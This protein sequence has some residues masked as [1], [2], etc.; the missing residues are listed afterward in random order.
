MGLGTMQEL[1]INLQ[2]KIRQYPHASENPLT[3]S[4][5]SS[6]HFKTIF[7]SFCATPKNRKTK[8]NIRRTQ[9]YSPPLTAC[10]PRTR[11]K[12]RAYKFLLFPRGSVSSID[13]DVRK[14][15]LRSRASYDRIKVAVPRYV[16][17]PQDS[18]RLSNPSAW[19]GLRAADSETFRSSP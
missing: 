7:P 10:R 17:W 8:P 18:N 15:W 1:T 14:L 9:L 11:K 6:H 5:I 12:D 4:T 16:R 3:Q 19:K 13:A 2:T